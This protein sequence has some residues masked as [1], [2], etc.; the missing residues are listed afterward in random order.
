MALKSKSLIEGVTQGL[1]WKQNTKGTKVLAHASA[2]LMAGLDLPHVIVVRLHV[3]RV[4][5]FIAVPE[6][7]GSV[8]VGAIG[9][10]M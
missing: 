10:L 6:S 3:H 2:L 8:G 1:K 7:T 4:N 5:A 9:F